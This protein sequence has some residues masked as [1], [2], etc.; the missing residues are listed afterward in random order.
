MLQRKEA[1]ALSGPAVARRAARLQKRKL[2]GFRLKRGIPVYLMLAAPLVWYVIFCYVPMGGLIMVF[3]DYNVVD[4]F[5]GSPWHPDGIFYH[6]RYFLTY[7]KF[8]EVFRNTV[9]L[10]T[11]NTLFCFPA[12][13]LLA[14]LFNELKQGPFKKTVQTISYLPY[15]VSTIALINI[16]MV[17]L[18]G[19]GVINT[20]LMHFGREMIPF[21][22][23]S[24]YVI[25][26]YVVINLWRS[27]GWGTIIYVAAMSNI[28]PELYEAADIDGAGRLRKIFRI[29]LPQILPTIVILFI[30]SAPGLVNAD[31]ETMFLLGTEETADISEVLSTWIYRL[32]F[33]A[34][35]MPDYSL[36]AAVGLFSSAV[37]LVVVLT[38]NYLANRV[39]D[40]GLF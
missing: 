15:F 17:M 3:K 38:F 29:T 6:F 24:K 11:V 36:S 10:G 40:V 39:S 2:L 13:I 21:R 35:G 20:L 37:N 22:S 18:S 4:G 12:P 25:P 5:F 32:S 19:D 14:L 23:M 33:N 9:I 27:V 28:S 31:F 26:V 1:A 8:W 16:V 7:P 34:A 30:L